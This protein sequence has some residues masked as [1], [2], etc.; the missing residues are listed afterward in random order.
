MNI[1]LVVEPDSLIGDM[2]CHGRTH[3]NDFSFPP[4]GYFFNLFKIPAYILVFYTE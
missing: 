1:S 3:L 2:H 4:G